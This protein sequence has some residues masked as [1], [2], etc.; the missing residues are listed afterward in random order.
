MQPPGLKHPSLPEPPAWRQPR[1]NPSGGREMSL[2]AERHMH[3][4]TFSLLAIRPWFLALAA[5]DIKA[6]L[7]MLAFPFL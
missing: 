5:L 2:G 4:E 7:S 1:A 3:P 6:V